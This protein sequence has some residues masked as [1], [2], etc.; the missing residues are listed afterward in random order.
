MNHLGKVLVTLAII[1][2][3]VIPPIVDL[4]TDSHVFH[5]GWMPHARMH[6]VWLLGVNSGIGVL[7]LYLLWVPGADVKLRVNLSV[8]LS[9]IVFLAFYLSAFTVSLY[10]GAL[11]DLQG[12]VQQGPMG[13]DANMLT[14]TV[15]AAL[16][17]VGWFL[18]GR[19][20]A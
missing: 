9:L 15:A 1:A 7:A 4:T 5:H 6:T 3:A 17:I 20:G 18:N 10:G 14:F 2:Y 12:G 8:L 13:I 16:L 19:S 11:S